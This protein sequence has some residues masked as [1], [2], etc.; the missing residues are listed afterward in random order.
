MIAAQSSAYWAER[1]KA[2]S[3]PCGIVRSPGE[4]LT[5]D[6]TNEHNLVHSLPH[7]TA[8]SV[9]SIA[10]HYRLSETPGMAPVAAPL[11]GQHTGEVLHDLL[12]YDEARLQELS[13]SGS[14]GVRD[15]M[16]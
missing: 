4:A 13:A 6:Y 12:G 14:I 15:D 9:P 3:I 10:H 11:L 7:P 16:A 8:G 1:F 2:V 5:C